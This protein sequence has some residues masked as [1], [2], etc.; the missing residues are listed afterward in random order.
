MVREEEEGRLLAMIVVDGEQVGRVPEVV[1]ASVGVKVADVAVAEVILVHPHIVDIV[2]GAKLLNVAG[3]G[4]DASPVVSLAVAVEVG[5]H[6]LQGEQHDHEDE[7]DVEVSRAGARR[8]HHSHRQAAGAANR[9]GGGL[10]A[11]HIADL[12]AEHIVH[13]TGWYRVCTHQGRSGAEGEQLAQRI[14][15]SPHPLAQLRADEPA[16]LLR[17]VGQ[18]VEQHSGEDNPSGRQPGH[19][20]HIGRVD[21]HRHCDEHPRPE[22]DV[23]QHIAGVTPAPQEVSHP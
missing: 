7:H 5:S 22:P 9:D 3:G 21:S 10:V 12:S 11:S 6:V 17:L 2:I 8:L 19:T 13:A 23:E 20:Q 14:A 16:S 1:A 15:S 4:G 18:L